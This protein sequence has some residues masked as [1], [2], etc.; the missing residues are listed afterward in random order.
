MAWPAVMHTYVLPM[1]PSLKSTGFMFTRKMLRDVC[2]W[3]DG[4]GRPVLRAAFFG[5]KA[6]S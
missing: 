5:R 2:T 3:M 1:F 4:A 6:E